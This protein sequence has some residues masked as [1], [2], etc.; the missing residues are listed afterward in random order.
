VPINK[1]AA[2]VKNLTAFA[3]TYLAAFVSSFQRTQEEFRRHRNAFLVVFN[4][5]PLDPKGSLHFR[6]DRILERLERS[7]PKR[8]ADVIRQHIAWPPGGSPRGGG[9]VCSEPPA[10]Q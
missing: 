2:H 10:P 6:W 7:D 1:R 4:E 3:E 8:L 9:A 5:R